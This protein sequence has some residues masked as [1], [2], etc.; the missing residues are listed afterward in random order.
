M[1][2]L[3]LTNHF[4]EFAGSEIIAL[5]VAE[6]F[7][8]RGD[9]VVLAANLIRPPI[10]EL[11]QGFELNRNIDQI[12]LSS[13]DLVWCQH[14]QLSLLPPA[15]FAAAATS[16]PLIALVSLSPF[17]PYEHIDGLI[18]KAL[19]AQVVA[20]SPET[21][22]E[23]VRRN[24]NLISRERVVVFHNAA[25]AAF[26][27]AP[28]PRPRE[29]KSL[30]IV[31]NHIPPE[32]F[33]AR[34]LLDARG[35]SVRHI[36]L[37]G[38]YQRIT[39]D[40]VDD[41]DALIT[42]GKTAVCGVA[43]SRPV[44]VYDRFGGS[45]W[46]TRSNFAENMQHNFSGRPGMRK[47]SDVEIVAELLD[48]FDSAASEAEQLGA[49]HDLGR[50]KLDTHLEPLREQAQTP[51]RWRA[52]KLQRAL[53]SSKFRAHLELARQNSIVMRRSYLSANSVD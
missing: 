24:H 42:I 16:P 38:D 3:V 13:F 45:G 10:S 52:F 49:S 32:L 14:G 43:R 48:G 19:S 51:R 12:D 30:T 37:H 7:R 22:D 23:Q 15:A 4:S 26:W 36:G 29:L 31:S 8:E 11:A 35:V 27:R 5:E 50:F 28:S 41:G 2:V 46:L 20:N 53:A 44:Y 17:E 6:W 34:P 21:A 47:L 25:P 18:A 40:D 1:R 39:A 33:A 9:Q